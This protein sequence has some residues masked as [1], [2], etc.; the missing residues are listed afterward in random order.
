MHAH[1][2]LTHLHYKAQPPQIGLEILKRPLKRY[3]RAN[4]QT[5]FERENS[6]IYLL[7]N[8]TFEQENCNAHY[9]TE[10]H[11]YFY[12]TIIIVHVLP[13]FHYMKFPQ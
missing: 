9:I 7:N 4:L 3:K 8:P 11:Y 12:T 1:D 5:L 10:D 2:I 6:K 13:A